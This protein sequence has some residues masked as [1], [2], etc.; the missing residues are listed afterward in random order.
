MSLPIAK[1]FQGTVTQ[2]IRGRTGRAVTVIELL[3]IPR[4][5]K[6]R[7]DHE[8]TSNVL[9]LSECDTF[10]RYSF[11][12]GVS[13]FLLELYSFFLLFAYVSDLFVFASSSLQMDENLLVEECGLYRAH[14]FT[15]G[16]MAVSEKLGKLCV[17]RKLD[18][19]SK[20]KI[21]LNVVEFWNIFDCP[22]IFLERQ[23]SFDGVSVE[24]ITWKNDF[25]YCACTDGSAYV[26]S[27]FLNKKMRV[28]VCPSAL[29]CCTSSPHSEEVFFG[30]DSGAVFGVALNEDGAPVA[31]QVLHV[32]MDRRIL[33]IACSFKNSGLKIAIGMVDRIE[34]HCVVNAGAA[35]VA[36]IHIDIPRQNEK[37]PTIVWALLFL[38]NNVL[39]S[40]DSQGK[41][42][43]WNSNNGAAYKVIP[44]HQAD[45]L[46][47][48]VSSNDTIFASGVDHRIQVIS[49]LTGGERQFDWSTVGQRLIHDIDVRSMATYG[50]WLLSGGAEH[51]ITVSNPHAIIRTPVAGKCLL[52]EKS[53]L[54][55]FTHPRYVEIWKRG[56]ANPSEKG[57]AVR[58]PLTTKPKK[59]AQLYLPKSGHVAAA[60]ISDSGRFIA[61]AGEDSLVIYEANLV[62][63]KG[64]QKQKNK[65]VAPVDVCAVIPNVSVTALTMSSGCC[66]YAS[67]DFELGRFMFS[68]KDH[69]PLLESN[70]T[71]VLRA[72]VISKDDKVGVALNCRSQLIVFENLVSPKS[73]SGESTMP[74]YRSIDLVTVPIDC[75]F[76]TKDYK[77]VVVLNASSKFA[78]TCIDL[79]TGTQVGAPL[80]ANGLFPLED[81]KKR[82][83]AVSISNVSADDRIVV[84]SFNGNY[85]IVSDLLKKER[86]VMFEPIQSKYRGRSPATPF[87]ANKSTV[88]LC[89]A[90]S[91]SPPSQ[92]PFKVVRYDHN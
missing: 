89:S 45:I 5:R 84:T 43:F 12:V 75:R 34:I 65:E 66:Y 60:A 79:A 36:P 54:I 29:W 69:R 62:K 76:L 25:V 46:C 41:V 31:R 91:L 11:R 59:L 88:V 17:V 35:P 55:L 72:L 4:V 81:P 85:V 92:T 14:G 37:K 61:I 64:K 30:A 58:V 27:P 9:T 74:S 2:S 49:G 22:N 10:P 26:L 39:V 86:T 33:S 82:D 50:M 15:T 63:L 48:T 24:A 68:N 56:K 47:L 90:K 7:R 42:T 57:N 83:T 28:Q 44:S 23:I 87:W 1:D 21:A 53:E 70:G 13:A 71:S 77:T 78:L 19:P 16:A 80:N 51:H 52:T 18:Q 40:G 6:S 20:K 67:G 8:E 73:E 3:D 38:T 32:G